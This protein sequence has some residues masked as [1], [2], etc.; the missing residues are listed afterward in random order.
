[1]VL[2]VMLLAWF[3][4]VILAWLGWAVMA[5]WMVNVGYLALGCYGYDGPVWEWQILGVDN[6]RGLSAIE[7]CMTGTADDWGGVLARRLLWGAPML[8]IGLVMIRYLVVNSRVEV[9]NV[10]CSLQ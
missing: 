6:W 3:R 7:S 1:V 9:H 4:P 2:A 5:L 8:G 10:N